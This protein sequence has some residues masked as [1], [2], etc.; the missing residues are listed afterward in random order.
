MICFI[1]TDFIEVIYLFSLEIGEMKKYFKSEHGKLSNQKIWGESCVV[2]S[3]L[4]LVQANQLKSLFKTNT[5]FCH[6][7]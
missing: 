3:I 2:L 4:N 7:L 5:N 6:K 1:L